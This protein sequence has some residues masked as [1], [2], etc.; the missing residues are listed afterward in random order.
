MNCTEFQKIPPENVKTGQDQEYERHA[1]SC[2]ECSELIADLETIRTESVALREIAEPSPRV[3][4]RIEI[5]L[6]QEGLIHEPLQPSPEKKRPFWRPIWLA[7][8]ATCGALA[9]ALVSYQRLSA[10]PSAGEHVAPSPTVAVKAKVAA[11]GNT[12]AVAA[13]RQFLA[14]VASRP[15]AIRAKYEADLQRVNNY[16]RDAQHSVEE[17]PNDEVA[18]QYLMDAYQQKATMYQ[19]AL[20]RSLP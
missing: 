8:L 15:P 11:P 14:M 10:P 6:R 4:N 16:I 3:W 19:L 2:T 1:E 13:D 17:D 9:L 12:P 20:D 18:Q 5:A 7:P